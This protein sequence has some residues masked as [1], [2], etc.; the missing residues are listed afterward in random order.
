MQK[1]KFSIDYLLLAEIDFV[2]TKLLNREK[3]ETCSTAR[4]CQA[5]AATKK[6]MKLN[7]LL[8]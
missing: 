2:E 7:F 8:A 3:E 5:I 4:L 6:K 1:K